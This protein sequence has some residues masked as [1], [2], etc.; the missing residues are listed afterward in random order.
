[1]YEHDAPNN[2]EVLGKKVELVLWSWR[3]LVVSDRI[4][5]WLEDPIIT[6]EE[7]LIEL[8]SELV[9]ISIGV[10]TEVEI[11]LDIMVVACTGVASMYFVVRLPLELGN[12]ED[13]TGLYVLAGMFE[14][15]V[16]SVDEILD[17]DFS[18][19]KLVGSLIVIEESV[20]LSILSCGE[21]LPEIIT[22]VLYIVWDGW[23]EVIML[24]KEP[25]SDEGFIGKDVLS[26][27]CPL[28][29]VAVVCNSEDDDGAKIKNKNKNLIQN[30]VKAPISLT[31]MF[32]QPS[33]ILGWYAVLFCTL[34]YS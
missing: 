5:S 20:E 34:A 28:N 12:I 4:G 16:I 31:T 8:L 13:G 9:K 3:E 15:V 29:V 17:D 2:S 21:L 27:K 32:Y 23:I 11:V 30:H 22:V 33:R 24:L 26:L 25:D 6:S 14:A 18:A 1:M 19:M 7:M 10:I